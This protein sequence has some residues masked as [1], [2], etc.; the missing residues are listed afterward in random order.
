MENKDTHKKTVLLQKRVNA[1]FISFFIL[2][3]YSQF[4][5]LSFRFD[6]VFIFYYVWREATFHFDHAPIHS[7]IIISV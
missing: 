6:K 7:S 2:L 4:F 5:P 1:F 3:I